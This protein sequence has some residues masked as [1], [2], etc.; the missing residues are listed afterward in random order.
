M[1]IYKMQEIN[2]VEQSVHSKEMRKLGCIVGLLKNNRKLQ[3][4]HGQ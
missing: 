1:D 3:S 2:V 4:L